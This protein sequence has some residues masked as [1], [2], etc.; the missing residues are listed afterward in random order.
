[1]LVVEDALERLAYLNALLSQ[2]GYEVASAVE[3]NRA[4]E[5]L[6]QID[7]AKL[8]ILDV[9]MPDIDGIEPCR[10]IRQ[11]PA[12][13]SVYIILHTAR[14]SHKDLLAGLRAGADDCIVKPS[15]PKEFMACV[16]IGARVLNL[17]RSLAQRI[18]E[19]KNV[20]AQVKRLHGILLLS[21]YCKRIRN[22]ENY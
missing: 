13:N 11:S 20:L 2:R 8:I 15:D 17:Q 5:L 12:L 18:E 10:R 21:S 14:S 6:N 3:G 19:L 22:D 4:W 9:M 7:A 16:Q 1:V